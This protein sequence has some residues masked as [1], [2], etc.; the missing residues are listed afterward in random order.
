MLKIRFPD[1]TLDRGTPSPESESGWNQRWSLSGELG[2][3]GF[4]GTRGKGW[5]SIPPSNSRLTPSDLP[6]RFADLSKQRE[7]GG[8]LSQERQHH[9]ISAIRLPPRNYIKKTPQNTHNKAGVEQ[10]FPPPSPS[11]R[12]GIAFS[13]CCAPRAAPRPASRAPP[14]AG[15]GFRGGGPV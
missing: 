9:I 15:T 4:W 2:V 13:T 12:C 10:R 1:P 11:T 6:P 7:H 14:Q 5:A 3:P 8:K